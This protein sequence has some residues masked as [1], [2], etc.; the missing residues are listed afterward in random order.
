MFWL[1]E[2]LAA[3]RKTGHLQDR[4]FLFGSWFFLPS[5]GGPL[6]PAGLG[7]SPAPRQLL[8]FPLGLPFPQGW[9]RPLEGSYLTSQEQGDNRYFKEEIK[10]NNF[11]SE[12]VVFTRRR[13]V[14]CQWASFHNSQH[15]EDYFC[16]LRASGNLARISIFSFHFLSAKLR[17]IKRNLIIFT[18]QL[19]KYRELFVSVIPSAFYRCVLSH[20]LMPDAH[21]HILTH[22]YASCTHTY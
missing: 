20:T 19:M 13:L 3:I 1:N 16:F 10:S 2:A 4:D 9:L 22:T 15:L 8:S 17:I 7:Q 18:L 14:G 6:T 11:K 12:S 21:T 5:Q